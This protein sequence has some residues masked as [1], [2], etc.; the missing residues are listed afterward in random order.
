VFTFEIPNQV[1]QNHDRDIDR[2]DATIHLLDREF[3][4][5]DDQFQRSV[6]KHMEHIDLLLSIQQQ[7]TLKI[8]QVIKNP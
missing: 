6:K 5:I 7:R 1:D 2:K 4:V 3:G 8:E